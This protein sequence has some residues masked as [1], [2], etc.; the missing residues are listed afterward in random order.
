MNIFNRTLLVFFVLTLFAVVGAQDAITENKPETQSC[1][2]EFAKFLV[3]QQ[4]AES[5][6]VVETDKRIRIL[7]RSGDFIWKLDQP[8]GREYFTE[9]F[10]VATDRFNE[11][12][13]EK[14]TDK[15]LVI[16][17]PDYRFEVIRAIAVKDGEWAKRL[18]EQLLKDYE[19][20]S[21]E[22]SELDRNREIDATLR[23]AQEVV[24]TNPEL[25]WH[26][27]RRVMRQPLDFYWFWTLYGVADKDQQFADALYRELLSNY[28]N[29]TPR[30]LLFLS[31]YPFGNG[32]PLGLDKFQFSASVPASFA[33]NTALQRQFIN[34]FLNRIYSYSSDPANLNRPREGYRHPEPL[35][36]I[37][38][39][40]ELE[41]IIIERF[42]DMLQRHSA[43][44][45]QAA[46]LMNDELGKELD[47]KEKSNEL[48]GRT[49]EERLKEIE[50][51][52]EEGK[53][54]D[55][56]IL[57]LVTWGQKT[58][59]QFRKIEPWLDKVK[60]KEGRKDLTNYF[61]FLRS[62]LAIKENRFEDAE[63]FAVK[64]P[65]MDHRAIL[66]FEIVEQKLENVS[67][68]ASV[69]QML[70]D[71]GKVTRHLENSVAK[72]RVL[73]GLA[74]LYEKFNHVFA[75]AELSDAVKVVNR[76]ENADMLSTSLFRQ[77]KVEKHAFYAAFGM[78]GYDLEGTF[79]NISKND[80]DM[81]LS[82]ARAL[83]DKYFRTLAVIAIAQN[84]INRP[85]P[86]LANGPR[87]KN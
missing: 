27:L 87:P 36:M 29:E 48:L 72:A 49:F 26:L 34:V 60:D 12:G 32:R 22:R 64:V 79:R 25:S 47:K 14:K 40:G 81:A 45:A 23:I 20:A 30:R 63:K 57:S 59:E 10:K 16:T 42:P 24:K 17:A 56:M 62:K 6:S 5:R 31:A 7:T 21:P 11:K 75:L 44:R 85:K 77:I 74:N 37:T 78:P 82:N 70:N 51:S 50:E 65:E 28:V 84:C 19:K 83:E 67:D 52:D 38:A 76:L 61:W 58:E 54:T 68:A 73:L 71:I 9:A 33:P 15:G 1:N 53:L 46:A 43:A 4:V 3:D 55:S 8:T 39:L 41:P 80:F 35:Y 2:D 66:L 13:F 86:R 18:T 69:Y